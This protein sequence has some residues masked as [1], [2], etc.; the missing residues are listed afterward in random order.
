MCSHLN[1][2][3]AVDHTIR[4]VAELISRVVGFPGALVFDT[5]KPDGTPRKWMC[6]DKLQ[7]LGWQ[8]KVGL[9]DGLRQAYG[10]FLG[11]HGG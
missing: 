5:S 10:E 2:G 3:S 7:A 1:V 4:E 6:S 9:E 11:R 8:P